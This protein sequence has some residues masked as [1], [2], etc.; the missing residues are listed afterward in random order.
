MTYHPCPGPVFGSRT[1]MPVVHRTLPRLRFALVPAVFFAAAIAIFAQQSDPTTKPSDPTLPPKPAPAPRE[2]PGIRL[3]D[4][5]YL[6]Y[7][8]GEG[9]ERIN[10]TPQEFQRLVDQLDQLKKQVAAKKAAAPS[11]CA[12]RARVEK[13]GEQLVAVVKLTLSFRTTAPQTP[14]ALGGKKGF[15]V[16]AALDGGKLPILDT[17]EDGFAAV[18]EA[19]GDHTLALDLEAPVTARGAKPELGFEIGL[20]RAAITTL[21]LE[22]P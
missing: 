15:L 10:L 4:G 17:V 20:P 9:D 18:I 14:V 7:G 5:T 11:G 1:A 19:T 16:A 8:P 3:P 2:L 21:L 6:W 22:P 12:I 13:R